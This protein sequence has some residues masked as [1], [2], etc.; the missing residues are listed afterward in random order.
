[1][2]SGECFSISGG[3]IVSRNVSPASPTMSAIK[4][5]FAD[6]FGIQTFR[7]QKMDKVQNYA[8]KFELEY[9]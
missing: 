6:F 8:V 2:K 1:M 3:N 5:I 7:F 9:C 4:K